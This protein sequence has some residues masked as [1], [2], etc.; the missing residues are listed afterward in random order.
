MWGISEN[1]IQKC[2]QAKRNDFL[3]LGIPRRKENKWLGW[4]TFCKKSTYKSLLHSAM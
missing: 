2:N 3:H 1:N 4:N